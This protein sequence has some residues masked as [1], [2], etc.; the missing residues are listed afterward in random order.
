[1]GLAQV[2]LDCARMKLLASIN[3]CNLS[4]LMR[5]GNFAEQATEGAAAQPCSR[6]AW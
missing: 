2:V 4:L 1:M 5:L 6:V 3:Q